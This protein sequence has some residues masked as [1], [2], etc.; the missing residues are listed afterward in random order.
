MASDGNPLVRA[1]TAEALG[2]MGD[3]AAAA[4]LTQLSSDSEPEVRAAADRSAAALSL[5][6]LV[7]AGIGD[8][9][10]D[11]VCASLSV[12]DATHAREIAGRLN[13]SNID[14]RLAAI[15]AVARNHLTADAKTLAGLLGGDVATR[16][17]AVRALGLIDAQSNAK[18]VVKLLSD[19]NPTVRREATIALVDVMAPSDAQSLAIKMLD[20]NDE[21]VRTS[22]ALALAI[23]PG[24]PAVIPMSKQLSDPYVPLHDAA[25]AALVAAGS[26][27][28]SAAVS[29]LDSP[30]P[31]RRE[32]GSYLLGVLR[33]PAGFQRHLQLLH[34]SDWSV[35]AQAA[36]SLGEISNPA[37]GPELEQTYVCARDLISGTESPTQPAA[38]AATNAIVSAA[39][40]G[41][42]PIGSAA[43][44]VI[45]RRGDYPSNVRSA[46]VWAM[47]M[48]GA[49]E[50]ANIFEQL[51]G[52]VADPL[53]AGDIKI[54]A[55]KA[56]G[57]RKAA[58][59]RPLF[60]LAAKMLSS[61][62][63]LAIIHWSQDRL[64]GTASP[65]SLPPEKFVA[66]TAIRDTS[67]D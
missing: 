2:A 45:F 56:V 52:L 60:D 38:I 3:P 21:S 39:Q 24:Q 64:N 9:D 23:V 33:S 42:G 25:R 53:E 12:A 61:D 51:Q 35:V 59:G 28:V 40:L 5:E 7:S 17:A 62:E 19:S 29:L 49:N 13:D 6:T 37:A 46:A 11:V 18:D 26:A 20:D 43:S 48:V 30:D 67:S 44:S 27:S 8:A 66:D 1:S 22:A 32:D 16:V 65:F 58:A 31:R 57:N 14:I 4:A 41:Y 63:E 47:G 50:E 55:V 34:D 54:E 36:K 15:R 10:S